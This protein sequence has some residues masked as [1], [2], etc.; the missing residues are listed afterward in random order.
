[1]KETCIYKGQAP[2]PPRP[3]HIR[4]VPG[5]IPPG[6]PLALPG[7]CSVAV[8]VVAAVAVVAVV[9]VVAVV[10]DVAAAFG[11]ASGEVLLLALGL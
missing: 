5:S 11:G 6:S 4:K 2:Q 1:M 9:P 7:L 8:P 10:A 3:P